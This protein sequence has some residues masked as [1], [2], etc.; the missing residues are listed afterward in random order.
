KRKA[1]LEISSSYLYKDVLEFQGIKKSDA[2]IKLLKA[3]A[4]QI[5]SE[6]SYTELAN[7]SGLNKKTVE[8]YVDILEKNNI[9]FRLSPYAGNLRKTISKLRK[10]YFYDIGIRNALIGDFNFLD[11]RNDVGAL[12]ENFILVER[13]K[14]RTYHGIFA[15]NYFWRTYD[16]AEVDLVEEREGKL[17]GYEFKWNGK[18]RKGAPSVYWQKYPHSSYEIISPENVGGFVL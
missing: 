13:L 15:N 5:G 3:L 7:V 16:G 9:I 1:I 17:F 8:N 4:F 11:G 18:K 10:I 12:W 2:M 6:V 14:F